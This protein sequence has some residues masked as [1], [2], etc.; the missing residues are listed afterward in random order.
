MAQW[1]VS[2][3]HLFRREPAEA[4]H[5]AERAIAACEEYQLPL[6]LSQGAF[7]AGWAMAEQ[8]DAEAGIARM[9]DGAAGVAPRGRRMWAP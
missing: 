5:W 1:G 9:R 2:Y 6:L 7:Q 3:V 8:G 4:R